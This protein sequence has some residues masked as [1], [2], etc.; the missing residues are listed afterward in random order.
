M[1]KNVVREKIEKIIKEKEP[2]STGAKLPIYPG[3][4]FNVYEI[5]IEL[6]TP[7]PNNDRIASKIREAE[8]SGN[9]FNINNQMHLNEIFDLL[10]EEN[11]KSNKETMKDI[12][13]KGQMVNG[14]ISKDGLIIDGNR[15]VSILK[16]LYEGDA[17]N[18]DREM[19]DF[20]FFRAIILKDEIAESQKDI[21]A[22][23]TQLQIGVDE[24]VD[25]DPINMY[26]KVERLKDVG[27]NNSQIANLM[28]IKEKKVE[29]KLEI[30]ERM[31][32]F[33]EYHDAKNKFSLLEGLEDHFIRLNSVFEKIEQDTYAIDWNPSEKDKMEFRERT[34]EILRSKPEGKQFR[35]DFLGKPNKPDGILANQEAWETFQRNHEEIIKNSKLEKESDWKAKKKD[36]MQNLKRVKY[37]QYYEE[38]EG[39]DFEKRI[40]D[41]YKKVKRLNKLVDTQ[42]E[43]DDENYEMLKKSEQILR[44]LKESFS[45]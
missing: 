8:S 31:N 25:Y 12:A 34:F 15:R 27:Y 20:R 41:I 30:F 40:Q 23:E 4:D 37:Q 19:T 11:I 6:L 24:K 39:L 10:W 17:K 29:E 44:Q 36:F 26:I 22:L 38:F 42:E 1:K 16:K 14:V 3:K 2:V 13:S 43:I 7:N 35:S 45:R 21:R 9:T 18:Y 32:E 5:P 33:L 28:N